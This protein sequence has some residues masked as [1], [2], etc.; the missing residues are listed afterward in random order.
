[1]DTTIFAP[2]DF[3][4]IRNNKSRD[5]QSKT[6]PQILELIFASTELQEKYSIRLNNNILDTVE[7][8]LESNH[9]YFRTVENTFIRVIKDYKIESN[10]VPYIIAI[11]GQL[12]DILSS[13]GFQKELIP[14]MCCSILKFIT[15]VIVR[16]NIVAFEDE[17]KILLFL[18]CIDNI[19]DSC[20]KLLKLSKPTIIIQKKTNWF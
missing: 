3:A 10:N 2:S 20:I 18:L 11:I 16:E 15:S 4:N 6:L 12:Y 8:L 7:K 19:I 5:T 14:D 1:M 17:T 9:Q 13:L